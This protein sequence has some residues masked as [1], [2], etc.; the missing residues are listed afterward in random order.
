MM[1]IPESYWVNEEMKRL[2]LPD[3]R[4]EERTRKILYDFSQNPTGSIPQFCPDGAAVK[5]VYGYCKNEAVAHEA[6]VEAQRHA[7]LER[8]KG[9]KYQR[10][11][12]VQDTTE[13]NFNHHP[14][15]TGLGPLDNAKVKGFFA[16]SSLAVSP[17]GL[18]L[19][20]LGQEVWV[21]EETEGPQ[22]SNRPIEEK[23][24]YKWIK[25]LH[26][27]SR[28][29]PAEVQLV[30]V[31][32]QESD[33][34]EYLVEPRADNVELLVRSYQTR[35][36][37]DDQKE[38]RAKLRTSRVRGKVEV[39]V[40]KTSDRPGRIAKCQVYYQ[41]VKIRP[42]R[43][44][45]GLPPDLKP[46]T[47]SAVLIR[48]MTPPDGVEGLEWLLLTTL[49]VLNFDQAC[50]V[51]RYYTFRWLVER[52]HFVLKSGCALEDRQFR[53][54]DRL[55]RFLALANIV[56][57]RLL[58]LTYLGR[59]RPD[60]PCT[61]AF[62]DYEWQALYSY[63]HKTAIFP[64]EPPSLQQVTLWLAQLGGFLGR[65]GDGY[66]GV[67]VLWRGWQRLFDIAQTWLIFNPP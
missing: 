7:T 1:S 49:A 43:R 44:R 16:H 22:A 54:A 26:E 63:I 50:E 52:F 65:K 30:Q 27:S 67:K 47:L 28:D 11:L 8:I 39:E 33:I 23:E 58:W 66:P 37:V 56:A 34:Y 62:E 48:E 5:G 21:R 32:D 46:V 64:Q 20:L 51:I 15:T 17:E 10:I 14:S 19:G 31:S 18:P 2:E 60:L 36:T 6:V 59:G 42:P 29:I 41:T 25:A 40:R 57:W 9:G 35:E 3:K 12:S 4:L 55:Q 61:V 24:S 45:P 53:R 38:V 13:Y